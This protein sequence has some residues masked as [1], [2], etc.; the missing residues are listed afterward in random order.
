MKILV[1]IYYDRVFDVWNLPPVWIDDLRRRFPRHTFVQVLNDTD[2]VREIAEADVLFGSQLSPA[3]LSA[4]RR[5]RWV[6]SSAAGIRALLFPEFVRSDITLTNTRGLQSPFIAEHIMALALALAR[7]IHTS[8]RRQV[9][10]VWAQ[11]EIS[12]DPPSRS[13]RGRVMGIVGL[14]DIGS[15]LARLAA[16]FEMRVLGVRRRPNQPKP[17]GV[18]EVYGPDRL[19]DLLT[20]SDIVAI[21][22]AHTDETRGLI[23]ARELGLMKRDAVL[24]NVARGKIVNEQDLVNALESGT[25]GGAGLDV[26]VSEPL[27]AS[28]P[29]WDLPNVVITPHTS[30]FN[31]EYWPN[32]INFFADNL[33]RFERGEPLRNVVDK[34]AGY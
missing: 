19:D 30:G 28:S 21:T 11:Q 8:V 10:H 7:K 9:D 5:L 3:A 27:P 6:Q 2:L 13:L 26:F 15:R 25:I 33:G 14:G 29:L 17:A 22:A 31:S 18:D 20:A 24:I 34:R 23:G 32:L 16:G 1:A 12:A 4:A